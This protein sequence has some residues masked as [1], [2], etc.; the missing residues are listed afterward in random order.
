MKQNSDMTTE[1]AMGHPYIMSTKFGDFVTISLCMINVC[2]FGALLD[3][4]LPY[5]RF[6]GRH[7]RKPLGW[8]LAQAV[9]GPWVMPREWICTLVVML[10]EILRSEYP[11]MTS[12]VV[13]PYCV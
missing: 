12:S 13:R 6:G 11:M 3:P 2:E 1:Q 7:L 4:S 10:G 5:V 9:L 8:S